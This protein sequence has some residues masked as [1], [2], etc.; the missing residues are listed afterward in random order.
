MIEKQYSGGLILYHFEKLNGYSQ[1]QHFVSGRQGGVSSGEKGELNLSFSVNDLPDNVKQNRLIVGEA[2]E[3]TNIVF[4]VQ[5]HSNRVLKADMENSSLISSENADAL[6]THEPG[7]CIAVLA[8]DCVPVLLYDPVQRVVAAIHAG[9]RGTVSGI[10]PNTLSVFMNDYNSKPE[11]IIAGIG[12]SISPSNYEVG[13][14]VIEAV[15]AYYGNDAGLFRKSRNPGRACL[16][17]WEANRKQLLNCGISEHN[18]ELAGICTYANSDRFFS[19][20]R[21]V[22]SGRFAA[23]IMIL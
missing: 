6:I 17:L 7:I 21:S 20:R 22:Q 18:I 19:A 2:L 16:D 8:A 10:V 23:G 5:V 9:W 3:I 12:P 13:K 15:N 11:D 1:I 4:A 14:E